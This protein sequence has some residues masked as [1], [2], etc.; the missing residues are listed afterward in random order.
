MLDFP[1]DPDA[2]GLSQV[3]RLVGGL[4]YTVEQIMRRDQERHDEMKVGFTGI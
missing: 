4:T 3:T 1:G 2:N